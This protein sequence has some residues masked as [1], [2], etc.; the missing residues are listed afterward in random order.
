LVTRTLRFGP[1]PVEATTDRASVHPRAIDDLV[2]AARHVL[3]QH[4]NN[5]VE[6]DQGR[7]TARLRPMRGVKTISSL[8]TTSAGHAFVQNLRRGHHELTTDVPAQDRVRVAF[9]A[10][11][12][13][14]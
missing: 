10:L 11:A 3:E 2:P 8:R 6:A 5:V 4:T 13:G 9:T 14:L 12:R 1:A 7:L